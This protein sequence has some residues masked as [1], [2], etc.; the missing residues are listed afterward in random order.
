ILNL[1]SKQKPFN[2]CQF[3]NFLLNDPKNKNHPGAIDQ[4]LKYLIENWKDTEVPWGRAINILKTSNGNWN[5]KDHIINH[6]KL[7]KSWNEFVVGSLLKSHIE[8]IGQK[9]TESGGVVN[10]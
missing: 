7:K 10:G 8:N 1:P 2:P 9:I 5:E 4:V 3:V 6:E